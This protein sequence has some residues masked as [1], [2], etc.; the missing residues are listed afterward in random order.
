MHI[1]GWFQYD[2]VWWTESGPMRAAPGKFVAPKG[3]PASGV[4]PG[5][6]GDLQ[7]GTFFRRVRP[8]LEGTFWE[9]F[10]YRFILALDNVQFSTT[11]ISEFWIAMN[12]IPGIGTLRVGHVRSVNGFEAG[13]SSSSRGATFMERSSYAE[14]IELNQQLTTGLWVNKTLFDEHATCSFSAYRPDNAQFSGS[15]F[16]D[17]QW[18]LGG[19]ATALP[20][21]E[22][23]GRHMLHLGTSW[24]WRSGT[25][26]ISTSPDRTLQLRTRP[27]LRDDVPAASAT[28]TQLV[29][30]G[31][32]N[33]MIDTGVIAAQS[34]W[35][36]GTELLYIRGP[37]SIQAEFGW[38]FVDHAIGFAPAGVVLTP[39]L[40]TPTSYTFDGG[41]IQIAYTLTGEHRSYKKQYATL[42]RYYF[43]E[44]GP[45]TSAWF[46]RD[47]NGH[48]NWG[49]GA[50]EIAARYS[51]VNLNDGVGA[52]RIQGG[53]MD[54]ISAGLNWYLSS[55][56]MMMFD[57]I[58][59]HRYQVPAGTVPGYTSGF[60]VQVQFL[61]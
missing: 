1:G 11:G 55:N 58:Y 52:S 12:N 41:Y 10:E 5:G 21:Y 54:G 33:R 24:F 46:V 49:W 38:N 25:N 35:F 9:N 40:A 17:G 45:F 19:R 29:P 53:A 47:E 61:F 39:A 36:V 26:N 34:D 6:I 22:C 16:G 4:A 15:F 44:R 30:N 31:N 27:E 51:Y 2:T 13:M 57:Y 42:S 14:A 48:L 59:D 37:L 32:S 28:G 3:G 50:W 8:F 18:G 43:G 7:D 60:G 56:L 23:D 20:L